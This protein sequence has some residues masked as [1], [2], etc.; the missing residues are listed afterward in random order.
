[1]AKTGFWD[2]TG[3]AAD[4]AQIGGVLA[5][6][7]GWIATKLPSARPP[8]TAAMLETICGSGFIVLSCIFLIRLHFGLRK[9]HGE[10]LA[11]IVV[12]TKRIG[13]L[14]KWVWPEIVNT[15]GDTRDF[16]SAKALV[17][18]RVSEHWDLQSKEF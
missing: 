11:A 6:G 9:I 5:L 12:L 2:W 8:V 7:L 18:T 17:N 4:V 1:M 10:S 13:D 16:E 15:I 14:E 3:R